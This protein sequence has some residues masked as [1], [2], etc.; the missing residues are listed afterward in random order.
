MLARLGGE[1]MSNNYD[2]EIL[3]DNCTGCLRCQLACSELYTKAYN[4]AKARIRVEL[5][6]VDCLISFTDECNECGV[7][8]DNCFFEALRKTPKDSER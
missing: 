1:C 5:S 3:T 6:G 7:C 2:I 4:P 8:A